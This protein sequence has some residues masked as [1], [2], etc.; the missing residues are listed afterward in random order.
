MNDVGVLSI[1]EAYPPEIGGGPTYSYNIANGLAKSKIKNTVL[2]RK[3]DTSFKDEDNGYISVV[4]LDVPGYRKGHYG[5]GLNRLKLILKML[6]ATLSMYEDY[7]IIHIYSGGAT[8]IVGWALRHIY[9]V[10]KPI[11][12]TFLGSSVGWHSKAMNPIK[13]KILDIFVRELELGAQYDRYLVV[14]D[15]DHSFN[16][17]KRKSV[18]LGKKV[19]KE[20]I[21][22]HYQGVDCDK[23]KPKNVRKRGK[24]IVFI[25]RLEPLKGVDILIKS[26]PKVFDKVEDLKILIIGN[27]PMKGELEQLVKEL[28]L[29][30]VE[31]IG[32]VQHENISHY[33]NMSD[34]MVF[35]DLY[36]FDKPK[37]LNLTHCE[38]MACG[39]LILSSSKPRKEWGC[40][41][42]VEIDNPDTK[43]ISTKILDVL[44]NPK[45][46]EEIRKNAR[47]TALKHFSWEKIIKMYYEEMTD[48]VKSS[49][50]Q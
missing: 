29:N 17:L 38:A 30:S 25:G 10:E 20:K 9:R 34:C 47:K 32:S 41:T 16:T 42:W 45:K 49:K 44:E 23:F 26:L 48:L 39:A 15:G 27:G 28:G 19:P 37:T 8:K 35:L 50:K 7:D 21:K 18:L 12:L 24:T 3:S 31:F 40:Q 6:K 13:A 14:D 33:M 22:R 43:E 36:G 1:T 5:I 2:T 11:V 4:R 46:Y